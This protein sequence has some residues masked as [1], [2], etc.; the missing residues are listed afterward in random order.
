MHEIAVI[1]KEVGGTLMQGINSKSSVFW[2]I[3]RLN[4]FCYTR[5]N[6][7][8]LLG[9]ILIQYYKIIGNSILHY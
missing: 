5:I 8:V 2:F 9:S 7:G 3:I 1:K 6:F 4:Q